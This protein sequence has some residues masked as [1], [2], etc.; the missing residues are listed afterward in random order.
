MV[1]QIYYIGGGGILWNP[2]QVVPNS[3]DFARRHEICSSSWK[4]SILRLRNSR[5]LSLISVYNLWKY[6]FKIQR[7]IFKKWVC[8]TQVLLISPDTQSNFFRL[9]RKLF[10]E[11][12]IIHFILPNNFHI[13]VNN[14][15]SWSVM[16]L[17]KMCVFCI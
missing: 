4:K 17:S 1:I 16:F 3:G 14:P 2:R 11:R 13:A 9:S 12:T 8:K 10:E 7:L 15:F 6:L 5:G